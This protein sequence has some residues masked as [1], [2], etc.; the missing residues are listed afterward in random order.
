MLQNSIRATLRL[1]TFDLSASLLSFSAKGPGFCDEHPSH[2]V[3]RESEGDFSSKW[4]GCSSTSDG[5]RPPSHSETLFQDQK[6]TTSHAVH[7]DQDQPL[8]FDHTRLAMATAAFRGLSEQLGP[9]QT[10]NMVRVLQSSLP[11]L[12]SSASRQSSVTENR[13]SVSDGGKTAVSSVCRKSEYEGV[14]RIPGKLSTTGTTGGRTAHV[15]GLDSYSS[16]DED[17]DL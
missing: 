3:R 1:L 12:I 2:S 10:Q 13:D 5:S 17:C 16:S 7:E 8:S 11:N 14:E 4:T 9:S 15:L 6:S